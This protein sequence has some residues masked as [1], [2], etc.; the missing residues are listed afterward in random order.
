MRHSG[1]TLVE[2]MITVA[3]MSIVIGVVVPGA[4]GFINHSLL[5][6]EINELSALARLARFK[7]MEER[8]EVILCPTLNYTNCVSNWTHPTM[9]FYDINGNSEHDNNEAL[10]GATEPLHHSVSIQAPGQAIVFDARGGASVTTTISLCDDTGS[11]DKAVGLI[12]NGYGKIAI[13]QDYNNDGI[14]ENHLQSA[15]ACS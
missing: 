7:A 6:K 15:L 2:L 10:L 14:N 4:R 12:I 11:A 9:A 13:A 3:I 8:T 1:Y 5:A